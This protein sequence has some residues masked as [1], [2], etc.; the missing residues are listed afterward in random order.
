ME[1]TQRQTD[2]LNQENYR[3]HNHNSYRVVPTQS[4]IDIFE[5][6]GFQMKSISTAHPKN[7]ENEGF[8]H[9]LVMLDRGDSIIE[10]LTPNIIISN[11]YNGKKPLE[12]SFGMFRFACSNGLIV[13]E[14]FESV[15]LNHK[16]DIASVIND[17]LPMYERS[18]EVAQSKVDQMMTKKLN[19]PQQSQ[20]AHSIYSLIGK[21]PATGSLKQLLTSQREEDD[22]N[23]IFN[24][25][26]R[27]QERIVK[28]DY[29]YDS[30]GK[31][32]TGKAI[33]SVSHLE[34]VNNGLYRLAVAEAL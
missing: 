27:A 23:T 32:R 5:N 10:G 21:T 15:K 8:Q 22:E 6:E 16:R 24:L 33:K 28:G 4:V 34:S 19:A 18:V 12:V 13:G 7:A 20:F 11:S 2:L 30:N 14:E 9:H 1:I 31:I 29:T 3:W 17:F 26:N 25:Y